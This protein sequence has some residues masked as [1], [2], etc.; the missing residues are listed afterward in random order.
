MKT[1]LQPITARANSGIKKSS[2][3]GCSPAKFDPATIMQVAQ[4][5][6][7]LGGGKKE[8]SGNPVNVG[9]ADEGYSTTVAAP[10]KMCSKKH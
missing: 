10:G 3:C 7:S 2:D 6:G 1:H 8:K 4:V 9:R 5:A